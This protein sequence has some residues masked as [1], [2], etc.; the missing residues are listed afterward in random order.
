MATL[1]KQICTTWSELTTLLESLGFTIVNNQMRWGE[2]PSNTQCYWSLNSTNTT[3]NFMKS[4]GSTAFSD[5]LVDMSDSN[6]GVMF[7]ALEDNGCILYLTSTDSTDINNLEFDCNGIIVCTPEEDDGYWRYSWREY[8]DPSDSSSTFKWVID[9]THGGVSVGTEFAVATMVPAS[10]LATLQ[11]VYFNSG[12]WSKYIYSQVLGEITPPSMIF[13]IN[14]QKWITFSDNTTSR[15]PAFKLPAEIQEPND[16]TQTVE[17]SP[18]KTYKV[19]HTCVWDGC[20]WRC[21]NEISI[22]GPFDTS[23]WVVTSVYLEKQR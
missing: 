13:K 18:N 20:L 3:I 6:A 8:R 11:K 14:G 12:C 16:P 22:P 21:V 2:A 10:M 23:D 1:T 19:N 4:S 7:T 9:N 17:F 15:C 5:P